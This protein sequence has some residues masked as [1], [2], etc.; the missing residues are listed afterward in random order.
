MIF[1][2]KDE[3][4]ENRDKVKCF[5]WDLN[6]YWTFLFLDDCTARHE[7]PYEPRQ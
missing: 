5:A 4:N 2:V 7:Y 1:I 6:I 3:H